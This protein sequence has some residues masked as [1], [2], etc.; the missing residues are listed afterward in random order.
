MTTPTNTVVPAG[1][2]PQTQWALQNY[3]HQQSGPCRTTPPTQWS[4]QEYP[5]NTVVPAGHNHQYSGHCRTTPTNKVVPAG[6]PPPTQ[7]SLQ[8]FLHQHSRPCR[9]TPTNTVGPAGLP[10]PTQGRAVP[11]QPFPGAGS[12]NKK[13]QGGAVRVI[14]GKLHSVIPTG[15]GQQ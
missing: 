14:V 9:T 8:D 7:S 5:T 3:L 4:M 10:P 12:G 1:L 15:R 11:P 2:P 13:V 6:L